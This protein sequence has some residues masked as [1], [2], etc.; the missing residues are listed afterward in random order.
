MGRKAQGEEEERQKAQ[1]LNVRVN[2]CLL[3]FEISTHPLT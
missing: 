3:F 2:V 1:L